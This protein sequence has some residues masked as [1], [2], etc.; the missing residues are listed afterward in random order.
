M[1]SL[2]PTL[3]STALT[4]VVVVMAFLIVATLMVRRARN[5]NTVPRDGLERRTLPYLKKPS[6]REKFFFFVGVAV[7]GAAPWFTYFLER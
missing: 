2:P 5:P 3:L 7:A 1:R 6:R 4:S